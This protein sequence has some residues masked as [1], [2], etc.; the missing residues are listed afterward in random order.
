[1]RNAGP[2]LRE[3]V[4]SPVWILLDRARDFS[5]AAHGCDRTSLSV[6]HA[7]LDL[8]FETAIDHCL[9][10]RLKDVK[11]QRHS[12]EENN[13]EGKQRNSRRSHDRYRAL[14]LV[15][16]SEFSVDCI[17]SR[18]CMSPAFCATTIPSDNHFRASSSWPRRVRI[19]ATGNSRPR[20]EG[21]SRAVCGNDPSAAVI[22]AF[23]RAF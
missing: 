2:P 6:Y 20:I 5:G 18:A 8:S 15:Q 7:E 16:R 4:H 12:W 1:M 19:C 10:A 14:R 22:V 9:V 13:V 21:G 11:R 23:L 3:D 17:S